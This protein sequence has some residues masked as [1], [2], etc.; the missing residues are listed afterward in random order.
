M[1]E[2]TTKKQSLFKHPLAAWGGALFFAGAAA[3]IILAIVDLMA[4]V[5]NPYRSLITFVG[6]PAV[7]LF[8]F[9]LF[10]LSIRLVVMKAR[11][12]GERVRF[13]FAIEPSDPGYMRNLWLFLGLTGIFI[14]LVAYSGY[15]GY[16]VTDSVGF[17]GETCHTVMHPQAV[18]YQNSAHA[19]VPCVECHIGP[20]ASFWVRSKVDGARQVIAAMFNTYSRPI[21]TP[22]MNLRPAQ[23]TCEGCHWPQQFYGQKLVTHTYYRS[24][25]ANSPW[26]VSMLV[27]IGGGNKRTGRQE[28]IHWHM[29]QDNKVEYIATDRKRTVIPWIRMTNSKGEVS[30]YSD[31]GTPVPDTTQEGVEIRRFDCMDCHNRPSHRFQAPAVAINLALSTRA[32][33][34]SLPYVRQ[35]GIDLL[36]AAYETKEQALDSI[37]KGLNGYYAA[38][39]PEIASSRKSEIDQS[40]KA[41]QEIYENNFF[42]EMKTD[43]RARENQLSHFTND[44]CFRCH[45]GV[46]QNEK[47]EVISH[48]CRT[49]HTIVAQGASEDMSQLT[50]NIIG[51]DFQHPEDIEDAWK[52]TKCTEC[53]T[54]ESGY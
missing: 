12:R 21:E 10:M 19:R 32:M 48:E 46:K 53:H 5:D 34:P 8:G 36:N 14:F 11:K 29:L 51:V 7:S 54:P 17:C 31:P 3:F 18:T 20:G 39:Y 13:N 43:Y 25:S 49:C 15:K 27:K 47:G 37:A 41:L 28:G 52:E 35:V 44:G 38:N 23:Q 33:T 24:D 22:V 42:P 45:D 6:A 4:A 1:A 40:V 50:S 26:T 9:L 30:I 16:E 2:I